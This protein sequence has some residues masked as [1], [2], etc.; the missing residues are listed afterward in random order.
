[1]REIRSSM[2]SS[3]VKGIL[4]RIII[5]LDAVVCIDVIY[6]ICD[7]D[8][9]MSQSGAGHHMLARVLYGNWTVESTPQLQQQSSVVSLKGQGWLPWY[10]DCIMIA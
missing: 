9:N 7:R 10:Y 1:M 6:F 5:R 3:C 8:E 2:E 4:I